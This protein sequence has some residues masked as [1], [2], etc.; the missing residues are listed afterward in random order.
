MP[1]KT[2]M[3]IPVITNETQGFRD[4]DFNWATPGEIAILSVACGRDFEDIDGYCGCRRSFGGFNSEKAS[5]TIL[6]ISTDDIS[7][8]HKVSESQL[9]W[10]ISMGR[11]F[12]VGD[13]VERRDAKVQRRV[14]LRD[15]VR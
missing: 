7:F 9:L 8:V 1:R 6:M 15:Q 3:L 2:P 13:V 5:T 12:K 4:S 11:K 14:N 10:I